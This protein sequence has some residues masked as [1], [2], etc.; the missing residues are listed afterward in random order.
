MDDSGKN[1]GAGGSK[2]TLVSSPRK[3]DVSR[4]VCAVCNTPLIADPD[5]KGVNICP[6]CH[7]VQKAASRDFPPGSVVGDYRILKKLA[8]GGMGVIYLCCPVNDL[9]R[10][11]VLKT[12]KLELGEKQDVY[13]RRFKRESELLSRLDH[14]TIVRMY[15]SWSDEEDAFIIMEYIDGHT[16][17]SIRKQ[18]LYLFDEE[19]V[20]QIMSVLAEA[21]D[22]AWEELKLLHRDIKP[23]NIMFDNEGHLHLLDFGIAK[24]L[25][26]EESTVLTIAGVGL[27]TPGYMS[28]E[29]FRNAVQPDCT[30][31]IYSLG[32]TMYFLVTGEPPFTGENP[33]V[34]FSEMLKHDPVPLHKRNPEISE[35]FSMLIQQT[36]DR[37]PKKRPFSWKKLLVNLER[38][39]QGRPPLLS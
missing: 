35:N 22:Y 19:V 16:L 20:I 5:R 11:L 9:S 13:A 18:D 32:A 30:T 28:P 12:L 23:S 38:V 36:L 33:S 2:K 39:S 27:G 21:L 26:S 17:E 25:E 3:T 15:D 6:H 31:D 29:Q 14:P 10:R 37:N 8:Q 7:T 4:G 1:L 34:V 24:S